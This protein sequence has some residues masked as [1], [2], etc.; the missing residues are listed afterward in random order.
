MEWVSWWQL[1][2]VGAVVL[3]FRTKPHHH[4]QLRTARARNSPN[5][6]GKILPA[7]ANRFSRGTLT[8]PPNTGLVCGLFFI[9]LA[10]IIR[11]TQSTVCKYTKSCVYIN[12]IHL[13]FSATDSKVFSKEAKRRQDK[14]NAEPGHQISLR[15]TSKICHSRSPFSITATEANSHRS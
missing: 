11:F 3:P 8:L 7:E 9:N 14:M 2:P 6:Q 10:K 4:Q 13:H 12:E 5:R 15:V 1:L